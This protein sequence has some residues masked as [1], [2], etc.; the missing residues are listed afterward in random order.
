MAL[1]ILP[2]CSGVPRA[3]PAEPFPRRGVIRLATSALLAG[4][5]GL[6][7]SSPAASESGWR[8]VQ[9][10]PAGYAWRRGPPIRVFYHDSLRGFCQGPFGGRR[11]TVGCAIRQNGRCTI[12]LLRSAP[13]EVLAHEKAH[14]KG[15][16]H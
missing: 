2:D 12:H 9:A 5:M 11:Y 7:L 6:V 10:P 16:R 14:C 13:R 4:L 1:P 3:L 8:Q 15:W